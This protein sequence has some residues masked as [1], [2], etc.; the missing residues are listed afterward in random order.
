[1]AVPRAIDEIPNIIRNAETVLPI[2]AQSS[3]TGGATPMGDLVLSTERLTRIVDVSKSSITVEAGVSIAALHQTLATHG[4]WFPPAPTW[5]GAFAGGV[6]A[7]NAAGAATFKYGP[8]RPW[9]Q[10]LT[11]VLA[12]GSI[13]TIARGDVRA[14]DG[15]LHLPAG[16]RRIDVPVPTYVMPNVP[17]RS[18]GYHAEPEMDLVDLFVGSEGTLGVIAR[19]TFRVVAP[20]PTVALALVPCVSEARGLALVADLRRASID[21][22]RSKDPHGVDASAIEH[23]DRRCLE[24]LREDG[25]DRR[26]DVRIPDGIEL[27]L[28]VQLELPADTT[29][30]SGFDQ[31]ESALTARPIDGG[32]SRFCRL[33][34]EHGVFDHTEMA[35]PG[36]TRRRDQLIAIR[37]A[38]P[39]G[40]NQRVGAAQRDVDPRI[41]KTAA[42]M[43]V[44]F[45]RFGEMMR[46]YRDGFTARGLDFAVWGHVSDGNVHPNVLPRSYEDVERGKEAIL[47]F[48]RDVARLGGCPLAEHGV[49][50]NPVKQALLRAL[51]GDAAIDEMR[52]VKRALDPTSRLA[53]GVIFE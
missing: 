15:W 36:Q 51:Y 1:M 24:I 38:V 34:N 45:E 37:E 23:M 11:V 22:W 13:L 31:I 20:A 8:V 10:G 29:E 9:V 14:R 49:G 53:P 7:T 47:A 27:A 25:A 6:V 26:H 52:A 17:K 16:D 5:T 4:A 35:L 41:A 19:V 2:G 46:I 28:L 42:D 50:R 39:A 21:T 33:L 40:V 30:A 43:I 18:A 3:L 44:P 32:L 48:G 12:D